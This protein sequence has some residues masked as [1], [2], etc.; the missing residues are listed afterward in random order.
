MRAL[1]PKKSHPKGAA[2]M[3]DDL[4]DQN[5]ALSCAS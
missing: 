2:G 3:R 5:V 1:P 4:D